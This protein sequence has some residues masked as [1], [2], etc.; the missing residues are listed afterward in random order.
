[1]VLRLAQIRVIFTY[2]FL[3]PL[4]RFTTPSLANAGRKGEQRELSCFL[5]IPEEKGFLYWE[6]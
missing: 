4:I 5:Q 3:T 1:M 6:R 2:S